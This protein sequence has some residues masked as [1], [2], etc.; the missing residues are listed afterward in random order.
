V[1]RFFTGTSYF[2]LRYYQILCEA[3]THLPYHRII[4]GRPEIWQI[5]LYYGLLVLFCFA[6]K[7]KKRSK[8]LII[9]AIPILLFPKNGPSGLSITNLDVGQGDCTCIRTE[10][11]V[12]LVD[13][14]SSDVS[15][16]G[17]YRIVPY[18]KSQGIS[19][20]EYI[21]LTHSDEDH[22]GGICEILKDEEHMGLEIGKIVLPNIE[23]QDEEYQELKKIC[24]ESGI[25]TVFMKKYDRIELGELILSCLHPYSSYDWQSEND[26]SLT[27]QIRYRNFTGLLMGD[28]EINGENELDDLHKVNYLKV[29]HHGS[30]GAS[31]EKFLAAVKPDIAVLSA[32]ENNRYGHPSSETLERLH[33]E[34]A[35][36]YCTIEGGAVTVSTDGEK[37]TVTEYKSDVK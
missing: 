12:V 27:L 15:E 21:F 29:G 19:R 24:I 20:I 33:L 9:L 10:D 35:K 32:G 34:G 2:I 25:E 3:T 16:V 30:K 23:K 6:S 17:K 7:Y 5:V 37:M 14:G 8:I 31:G 13:G 11:A 36:S 26:Y 22:V 1:G 28:L 4:T 18:L